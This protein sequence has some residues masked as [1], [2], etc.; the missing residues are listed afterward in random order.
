MWD[1]VSRGGGAG[2]SSQTS[3]KREHE[4]LLLLFT[5]SRCWLLLAHH[6]ATTMARWPGGLPKGRHDHVDVAL[7]SKLIACEWCSL[8]YKFFNVSMFCVFLRKPPLSVALLAGVLLR[9][10]AGDHA[11]PMMVSCNSPTGPSR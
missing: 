4:F 9:E 8:F 2:H 3:W 7:K 11:K 1:D 6:R 5:S 10:V